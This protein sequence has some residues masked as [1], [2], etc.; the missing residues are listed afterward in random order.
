M[1]RGYVARQAVGSGRN[2]H[3][4]ARPAQSSVFLLLRRCLKPS[5]AEICDA[6]VA[7]THQL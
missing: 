5:G 3:K 4:P 1:K 7:S 6:F 2:T